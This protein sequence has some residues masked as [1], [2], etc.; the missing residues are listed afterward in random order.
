LGGAVQHGASTLPEW[1]FNKFAEANAIEVHLATA[2]QNQLFDS[3]AFPAEL[4]ERMYAY[5]AE[6]HADERKPGQTDAQFFYTTRKR[7]FGPFKRELWDL[8]EETR[9][10]LMSGLFATFDLIMQR[11]GVAG[12][13]DLVDRYVKPVEVPVAAP[14][15]LRA[16]PVRS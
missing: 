5:L 15:S 7:A 16:T 9:N 13:A 6:H 12:K 2:F 4:R 1:A 10:Y 14:E 3:P 11:L 8:P